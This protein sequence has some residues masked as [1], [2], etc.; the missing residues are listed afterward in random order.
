MADENSVAVASMRNAA[1]A[2]RGAASQIEE[3]RGNVGDAANRLS[4]TFTGGGAEAFLSSMEGW[5]TN[6]RTVIDALTRMAAKLEQS[7]ESFDT[8]H[9][10]AVSMADDAAREMNSMAAGPLQGL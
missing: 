8:G 2:M 10:Q 4:R 3:L 6:G 5:H 7:A 1:G 9:N